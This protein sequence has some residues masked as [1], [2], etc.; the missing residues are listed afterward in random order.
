MLFA[1]LAI[2]R[3]NA[4]RRVPFSSYLSG[5][6]AAASTEVASSSSGKVSCL[7]ELHLHG[8]NAYL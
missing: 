3:L 7:G 8:G 4:L 2:R 6:N 1:M 5:A